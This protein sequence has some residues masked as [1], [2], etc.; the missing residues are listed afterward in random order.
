VN[1]SKND[2]VP[3]DLLNFLSSKKLNETIDLLELQES[4]TEKL[5]QS[6]LWKPN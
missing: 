3:S 5:L 4:K 2:S 1:E 6:M